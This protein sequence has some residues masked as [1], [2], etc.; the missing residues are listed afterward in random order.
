MKRRRNFT[1]EALEDRRL[2]A[3]TV[4]HTPH[5]QLGNAALIGTP[6]YQD[7]DQAELIWETIPSTELGNDVFTV[8][9]RQSGTTA[10]H[11]AE[12]LDPVTTQVEGRVLHTA[13]LGDLL[14]SATYQYR[15]QQ[16]RDNELY[17]TYDATFVTRPRP[18]DTQ[19]ITLAAYGDSAWWE[20]I[21]Q[22]A[23]VQRRINEHSVDFALLLGD[24]I[25]PNGTHSDADGRFSPTLNPAA[26]TWNASHVDYVAIGNH[27]ME[28]PLASQ[29]LFST[30][31]PDANSNAYATLPANAMSEF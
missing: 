10:W 21:E 27:D 5:L 30:P 24:N 4:N 23:G 20:Y 15:V 18:G 13:K 19:P 12:Q 6:A 29:Q 1:S 28:T 2:L 16:W 11:A 22:F 3:V 25:Y 31:V 7:A 17:N 8:E 9:Y 26:T 14:W